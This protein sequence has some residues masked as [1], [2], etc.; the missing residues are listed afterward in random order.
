M[1]FDDTK[2]DDDIV[3]PTEW[4]NLVLNLKDRL[5]LIFNVQSDNASPDGG[6]TTTG[7]VTAATDDLS[8]ASASTFSV[9]QG[10]VVVGAKLDTTD[11]GNTEDQ[12]NDFTTTGAAADN[13]WMAREVTATNSGAVGTI[14][15]VMLKKTGT[16]AGTI[17]AT[18]YTD[19]GGSPSGPTTTQVGGNS[20][21]ITNTTLNASGAVQTFTWAT[22]WPVL[23]TGVKYWLV[24]KT[25][26]YTYTNGVTEV[27]WQT[28][29][30][31]SVGNDE[32]WKFDS[33]AGTPWTTMGSDIGADIT[34]NYNL[35]TTITAISGTD[36]TLAANATT[37][38]SGAVVR[39]DEVVAIQAAH[40]SATASGGYVWFPAGTYNVSSDITTNADAPLWFDPAATL[41]INSGVT[42]SFYNMIPPTHTVFSGSGSMAFREQAI[43]AAGDT[44][45]ANAYT[46]VLNPDADYVMSSTPTIAN[47]TPGQRV[48]LRLPNTEANS[49]TLQD[50]GTL[51]S[52][53]LQLL[54]PNRTLSAKAFVN[55]EFDGVNW[56]ELGS[57]QYDSLTVG[58]TTNNT[59][60][61]SDGFVT[62]NGTARAS[63]DHEFEP[64]N[65]K[66]PAANFPGTATIG[67]SPVFQFNASSD[68]EVFGAFELEHAYDN[69]TDLHA[70]F[71]W[72]PTDGNAGN[73]TW[74][75]EWHT[76]TANNNE[77]LTE[78]TTTQ[79]I[80]DATESLQDE[81][82]LTGDIVVD[83]TGLVSEMTF[84]F[85]IFRDAD[86]SEG[87][88]SDTYAADASLVH[89]DIEI[90]IDGFGKD[91]QW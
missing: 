34:I 6:T 12:D 33:N 88:A 19:D 61:A 16:P 60:L 14:A 76:T 45:L 44:I 36:F 20:A 1:A 23:T 13:E 73:V 46:I 87:G 70:H 28:D 72:A 85:R 15:N 52:S 74:G 39:H 71:H 5:G 30:N 78:A 24:L 37:T 4:N 2:Q 75:L 18:I 8:V 40:T 79:I 81:V 64:S 84:H 42:V 41:S 38:V 83:G 89:F 90:M 27:I 77:V 32:C 82:L 67:I 17:L 54:A 47:G 3:E 25:V 80:V 65:L 7:S 62:L 22:D 29:A 51:G 49:V 69:G 31:G 9:N 11:T 86:A 35:S 57:L 50:Q 63:I 21:A 91:D 68:E 43:T 66:L 55:L 56:V 26:G 48:R 10:I 58:G 53:N 59:S